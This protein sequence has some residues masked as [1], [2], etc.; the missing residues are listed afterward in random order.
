LWVPAFAGTYRFAFAG[1][2]WREITPLRP[3]RTLRQARRQRART[4]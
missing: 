3:W 4:C 2:T 1:T